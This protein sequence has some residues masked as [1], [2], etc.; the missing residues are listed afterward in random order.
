[1][2][3]N[4]DLLILEQLRHIRSRVDAVSL[5]VSDIKSKMS[6]MEEMQVQL[7]D[8]VGGLGRRMDRFDERLARIEKRL[9]LE[10]A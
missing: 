2:T 7:L 4:V 9:D 10:H 8:M 5:D 1:M 6:S 3:N